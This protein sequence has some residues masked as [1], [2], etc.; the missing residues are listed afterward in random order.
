MAKPQKKE[1]P[2]EGVV[3]V[4]QDNIKIKSAVA[5]AKRYA[6]SAKQIIEQHQ[7]DRGVR[8]SISDKISRPENSYKWL[9]IA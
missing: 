1:D 2:K 6:P 3:A 4:T 7:K 8:M 9:N 5:K